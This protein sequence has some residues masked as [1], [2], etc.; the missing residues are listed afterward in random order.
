MQRKLSRA[1]V[2]AILVLGWLA[3]AAAVILAW[4]FPTIPDFAWK[5]LAGWFAVVAVLGAVRGWQA[6]RRGSIP[7]G[8]EAILGMMGAALLA[9]VMLLQLRHH[10]LASPGWYIGGVSLPLLGGLAAWWMRRRGSS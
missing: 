9:H 2:A 10:G 5:A 6:A 8:T 4:F 3:V 1:T 7:D